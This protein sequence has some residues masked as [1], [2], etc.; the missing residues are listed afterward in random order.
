[1]G[2]RQRFRRRR[3]CQLVAH[4]TSEERTVPLR[5]SSAVPPRPEDYIADLAIATGAGWL[6]SGA[7]CRTDRNA[8]YNRLL[9]IHE[10]LG[11]IAGYG[12]PGG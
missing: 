11:E 2:V 10:E 5:E 3:D 4:P 7:P 1:M 6:K 8:K 9:R 12:P